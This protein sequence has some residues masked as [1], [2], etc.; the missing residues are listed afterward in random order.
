MAE[1][2]FK[3]TEHNIKDEQRDFIVQLLFLTMTVLLIIPVVIIRVIQLSGAY[4]LR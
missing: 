3:A 1:S 2:I 4:S